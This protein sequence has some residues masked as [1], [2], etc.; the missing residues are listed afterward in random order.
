MTIFASFNNMKCF[1][2][3]APN[4]WILYLLVQGYEWYFWMFLGLIF[5]FKI[6]ISE[7]QLY[8]G[9]VHYMMLVRKKMRFYLF[10]ASISTNFNIM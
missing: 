4:C 9:L 8:Y 5:K 1:Y 10:F 2:Y 7:V 6:L 3:P